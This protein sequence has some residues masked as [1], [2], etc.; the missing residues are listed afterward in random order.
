MGLFQIEIFCDY[1]WSYKFH[2]CCFFY[3]KKPQLFIKRKSLYMSMY[4]ICICL[5][6]HLCIGRELLS[7]NFNIGERWHLH[8][9]IYQCL[10]RLHC[11]V[12]EELSVCV[13]ASYQLGINYIPCKPSQDSQKMWLWRIT[14]RRCYFWTGLTRQ[15][16]WAVC[17][18]HW[19]PRKWS[20]APRY[21]N[22]KSQ[23]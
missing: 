7:S 5:Q 23:I 12:L 11:K 13:E 14:H 15:R 8:G 16:N 18:D 4:F 3:L 1:N 17:R 21:I 22:T 19:G 10:Q 6:L 9:W 2:L 20:S